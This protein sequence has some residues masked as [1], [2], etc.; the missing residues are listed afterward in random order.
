[1]WFRNV[2]RNSVA[3]KT[4]TFNERTNTVS[5]SHCE[6]A[7]MW[8][9]HLQGSFRFISSFWREASLHLLYLSSLFIYFI[10]LNPNVVTEDCECISFQ[11]VLLVSV[12]ILP[13]PFVLLRTLCLMKLFGWV[14]QKVLPLRSSPEES[15]VLKEIELEK[16]QETASLAVV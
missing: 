9:S 6:A 12:W 7:W 14:R 15:Q 13:L 8:S 11:M 10:H 2:Q 3:W 4:V 16:F 1:M 5:L